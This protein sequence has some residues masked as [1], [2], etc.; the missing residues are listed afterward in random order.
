MMIKYLISIVIIA[1]LSIL[2][3][4]IGHGYETTHKE[5]Y[6]DKFNCIYE[7]MSGIKLFGFLS[8]A[9]NIFLFLIWMIKSSI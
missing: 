7:R 5:R 1:Y 9:I 8:L 6:T 2:F 3:I 4:A